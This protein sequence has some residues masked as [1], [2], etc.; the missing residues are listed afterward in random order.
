MGGPKKVKIQKKKFS[1]GFWTKK[2]SWPKDKKRNRS[3]KESLITVSLRVL[4][5]EESR[6]TGNKRIS[7]QGAT[8]KSRGKDAREEERGTSRTF[9]SW[10][11][12]KNPERPPEM[13]KS[14]ASVKGP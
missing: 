4:E 11:S 8:M 3:K 9:P 1:I 13:G 12:S 2:I 6:A 10:T 5:E 7:S 14:Y